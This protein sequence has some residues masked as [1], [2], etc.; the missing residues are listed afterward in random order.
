MRNCN[1]DAKCV[2][3]GELHLTKDCTLPA[4]RA[5]DDRSKI[6]CANCSQNHTSSYKGCP[7]RKNHI[8]ENEEKKKMQSSRRK[9]APALSHAPGG[10]SFRSTFVTPSKSF[11][12]AVKDGSSATVVAAAAVAVD[13][14][15]GGGGYA[16]PDQS[17]LFSLH[18]FMNLASDLFTRL[19]SCKTK[20]QQFLA[21]SELMIKYVYNG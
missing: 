3:C 2:K 9:D 5:T 10:R 17:E 21:L 13:G 11:A 14:A 12:D 6:R 1:M 16:G 4:R 7:A 20:A 19:S 18:E 8:Q 15:A